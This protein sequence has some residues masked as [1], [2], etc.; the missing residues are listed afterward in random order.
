MNNLQ[1]MLESDP[2]RLASIRHG[3]L[4]GRRGWGIPALDPEILD[5]IV[6][7]QLAR[8][9]LGDIKRGVAT[10]VKAVLEPDRN[11]LSPW[12]DDPARAYADGERPNWKLS[13]LVSGNE[14]YCL[15]KLVGSHSLN[16]LFG[17]ERSQC[18]DVLYHKLTMRP[19]AAFEASVYS[20][21][22]TGAY[23]SIVVDCVMKDAAPFNV[24]LFGTGR[25]A[26]AV[27]D[28]LQAH[29][30]SRVH[31]L[32]VKSHSA[33]RAAQFAREIASRVTFPVVAVERL[34]RMAFCSLVVMASNA[35]APLFAEEHMD[36][37]AVV[38]H[39]SG[40]ETPATWV[41]R[42][43]ETGTVICDDVSTVSHRNSQSL[44]LYFSRKRQSLEANVSRYQIHDLWQI[45]DDPT[46]RCRLPALV[47]CV[48][49]PVLDLYL[50]QYVYERAEPGHAEAAND[51]LA[52]RSG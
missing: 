2:E 44:A 24:F 40:D 48:G 21:Q 38:L 16:R 28:D 46:F 37:D 52:T 35:A 34:E 27:A 31:T 14:A 12:V 41:R 7:G 6:V 8:R 29:H 13:A 33:E 17:L 9:A 39:L 47:T 3:R 45:R 25:V 15:V 51:A 20:S 5:P 32:Y 42:V 4:A 36:R 23:A 18:H 10:G 26:A 50:A 22:R 49:L 43:L 1:A 30:A 19:V 11:E